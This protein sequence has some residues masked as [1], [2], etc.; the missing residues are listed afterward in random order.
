MI[1][2]CNKKS[3]NLL[4]RLERSMHKAWV[5]QDI[6]VPDSKPD[7]MKITNVNATPYINNYEV[8]GNNIKVE[9]KINYFVIY[10][11]INNAM[12]ARGMYMSYPF[13]VLIPCNN[14]NKDMNI[15]LKVSS[16]NIIFSL[17]NERKIAIKSE[18]LF[19]IECKENIKLDVIQSFND[20]YNIETKTAT[21]NCTNYIDTKSNIIASRED[22]MIKDELK[23]F[24]EVLNI[25]SDIKNIEYKESYNKIMVKGDIN[26]NMLY[27]L[28]S[29]KTTV[30]TIEFEVPFSGM[31]EF[32]NIN[33]K[34]KFMLDLN[35]KDLNI[36]PSND[37]VN[38]KIMSVEYQIEVCASMYENEELTYI[39]DFYSQNHNIQT[40]AKMLS[41][42][43]NETI[44]TKVVEIKENINNV[45]DG[46]FKIIEYKLNLNSLNSRRD[47]N[48]INL[49]GNI[50]LELLVQDTETLNL[51]N[52]SLDIMINEKIPLENIDS[53]T[54][55]NTIYNLDKLVVTKLGNDIEVKARI[56][57][58]IKCE[59]ILNINYA[60]NIEILD[61][62]DNDLDSM[63]MYM[64]K[65]DDN[66]WDIA[67]KYKTSVDKIMKTNTINKDDN[68][69][70]NQKILIIR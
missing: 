13:S 17:P 37:V 51:S 41:P 69:Y 7:V 32:E 45:L 47:N 34:S 22:I 16:K 10:D 26:I 57:L 27:L 60:Q 28:E 18:L 70:E 4:N 15:N 38:S 29:S 64:V 44:I 19:N 49:D 59:K 8:N 23:D 31:I 43:A 3:I 48:T 9:G 6:L 50:K 56:D 55:I 67:K 30:K 46:N 62:L 65:K 2:N 39:E 61:D 52:K 25:T 11:T 5:E 35:I 21:C 58:L 14:I 24:Y 63:Y 1:I 53:N 68:I 66:L 12:Q 33:D 54:L 40:D 42:I 36:V 20:E